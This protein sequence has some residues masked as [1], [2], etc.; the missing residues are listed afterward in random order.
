LGGEPAAEVL[1]N[2][3]TPEVLTVY[4]E[5]GRAALMPKWAIIPD[6]KGNVQVYQ[7]FWKDEEWDEQKLA[8]PLLIYADLMMT[9]DPRCQETAKIIY[10]KYLVHELG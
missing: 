1:T 3:L 5:K 9:G 10:D 6:E 4:T 8:P 7:K 2:Y